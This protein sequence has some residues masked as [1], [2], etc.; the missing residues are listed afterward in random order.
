M[1]RLRGPSTAAAVALLLL[2]GCARGATDSTQPAGSGPLSSG[3][4]SSGAGAAAPPVLQVRQ[5]G[6]F[7]PASTQVTRIPTVSVYDDGRVIT[8]GPQ[9]LIYPPPALPNLQVQQISPTAVDALVDK[10]VAAGVKSG[11]DLG[12]PPVADVPTTRFTAVTDAGPQT[13]DVVGLAEVTAGQPGLTDAQRAART[14]LATLLR[15]LTTDLSTTVGS[16][17]PAAVSY[18]PAAL[19]VV[20]RPYTASADAATSA[21]PA[22]AWPGPALPGEPL[23]DG[24]ELGCVAVTGA[25][26][27]PLMAAAA[28]ANGTT[29]WSSGSKQWSVT[30]RPLLPDENSCGDLKAA[31]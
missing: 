24:V 13:V 14:K 30:F 31:R 18:V 11:A 9:I 26:V 16:A 2:S 4:T 27:A 20:V 12:R 19:A 1:R 29:A 8:Q 23:G 5:S 22:V 7:V 10:A 6:G 25:Q 15:Q 3:P 21:G 28:K 17:V